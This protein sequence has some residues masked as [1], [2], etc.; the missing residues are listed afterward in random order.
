MSL[1]LEGHPG[2]IEG[3]DERS[4]APGARYDLARGM[5][6]NLGINYAEALIDLGGGSFVNTEDTKA[7]VSLRYSFWVNPG[8]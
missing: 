2:R 1:S 4:G 5:S 6:V 7:V 3:E 8:C